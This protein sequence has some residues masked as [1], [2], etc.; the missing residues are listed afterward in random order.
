MCRRIR[1]DGHRNRRREKSLGCNRKEKRFQKSPKGESVLD[2]LTKTIG[3]IVFFKSLCHTVRTVLS[4]SHELV[5]GKGY[6]ECNI[7]CRHIK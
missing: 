5:H 1:M 3:K 4:A 7:T 2:D 6:E